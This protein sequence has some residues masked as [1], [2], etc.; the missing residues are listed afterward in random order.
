MQIEDVANYLKSLRVAKGLTQEEVSVIL[1]VSN[2]TISKWET[3]NGLPEIQSLIALAD[4]YDVKVDDILRGGSSSKVSLEKSEI[5][6]NYLTNKVK[7]DYK[8]HSL[9]SLG[10]ALIAFVVAAFISRL[11]DNTALGFSLGLILF[12]VALVYQIIISIKAIEIIKYEGDIVYSYKKARFYQIL[13]VISLFVLTIP[14]IDDEIQFD[15]Y[16][17]LLSAIVLFASISIILF[18]RII[19]KKLTKFKLISLIILTLIFNIPILAYQVLPIKAKVQGSY[20]VFISKHLS[21]EDQNKSSLNLIVYLNIDSS[22]EID[23]NYYYNDPVTNRELILYQEDYLELKNR[24]Q[25]IQSSSII[26][27]LWGIEIEFEYY[28]YQRQWEIPN[29][30]YIL[31]VL[32]SSTIYLVTIGTIYK[33]NL[34]RLEE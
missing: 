10:I 27:N 2:K 31:T 13:F 26:S 9:I 16:K 18:D 34:K 7:T 29:H 32:I 20:S 8:I 6:S 19:L 21:D 23:G 4:L 12:L 1:N 25:Y 17:Y 30:I 15:E 3:G 24:F 11:G 5:R 28:S 33:V 14:F 22:E